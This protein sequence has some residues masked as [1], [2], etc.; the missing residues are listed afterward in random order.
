MGDQ[1]LVTA[2]LKRGGAKK[3][4]ITRLLFCNPITIGTGPI[5]N[6]RRCCLGKGKYQAVEDLQIRT[7]VLPRF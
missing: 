7:T 1:P 5:V 4:L 2:A 6:G 3:F